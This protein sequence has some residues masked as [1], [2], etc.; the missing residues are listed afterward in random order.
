MSHLGALAATADLA[1]LDRLRSVEHPDRRP[2]GILMAD[3]EGSS[4]L[5]RRLSTAQY[6]VFGRRFVRTADQCVIDAGGIIRWSYL[7][8]VRSAASTG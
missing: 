2:A 6:F 5:A 8:P 3:V 1:H 4:L 7:S